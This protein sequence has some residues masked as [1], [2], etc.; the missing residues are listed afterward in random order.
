M[1]KVKHPVKNPYPKHSTQAKTWAKGYDHGLR[2]EK[3]V[4]HPKC[5]VADDFQLVWDQGFVAG[6]KDQKEVPVGLYC[7]EPQGIVTNEN[8]RMTMKTKKCPFYGNRAYGKDPNKIA[9]KS[10]CTITRVVDDILLH[11]QCKVCGINEDDSGISV[12]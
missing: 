9:P 6:R 1:K 11:D 3:N 4:S 8:G 2:N 12:D 10:F 5:P 7:Y